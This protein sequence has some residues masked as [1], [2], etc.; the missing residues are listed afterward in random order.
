MET[1]G[2]R[3]DARAAI[4]VLL[5][6]SALA[7]LPIFLN[8]SQQYTDFGAHLEF[9]ASLVRTGSTDLP[10]FAFEF[11]VAF[12]Y[13]L[14]LS[15]GQGAVLVSLLAILASAGM[16][17]F[18]IREG[19]A[20]WT[21]AG[22]SLA[23][24][25]IGP[26]SIMTLAEK[27]LYLGYM[28]P[29]V[30]HNPT[31]VMLRPMALALLVIGARVF[32]SH[33]SKARWG[34]V[35]GAAILS[36]LSCLT[37]PS[38]QIAFLPGLGLLCGLAL[39]GR[40]ELD[41]HLSVLGVAVPSLAVLAWQY[42]VG[43]GQVQTSE[44]FLAPF[45][46]I[47]FLADRLFLKFALSLA[48]PVLVTV[49]FFKEAFRDKRLVVAWSTAFFGLSYAYFLAETGSRFSHGN[50]L[51]SGYMGVSVLYVA[52]LPTLMRQPRSLPQILCWGLFALQVL[53]GLI[54]AFSQALG[55]EYLYY[56]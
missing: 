14:G 5:G 40:K 22:L 6:V 43:F 56:W 32:D 15:L 36:A 2:E 55:E 31:Q 30:Y 52:C 11:A 9:V 38:F 51:W 8:L 35:A 33:V 53:S 12:L 50:F 39:I 28:T 48:F 49:F 46:V 17:F 26:L 13:A 20:P 42:S 54:F 25:F 18:I 10:H 4:L 1:G 41:L 45:Q 23:L 34:L 19:V 37:K 21:A 27:E 16:I 3:G 7:S 24:L 29:N 44:I 47:Q